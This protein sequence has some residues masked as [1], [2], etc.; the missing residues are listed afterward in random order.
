[1]RLR[2]FLCAM[3]VA[4]VAAFIGAPAEAARRPGKVGLVSF[5]G[6]SLYTSKGAELARLNIAWPAVRGAT[7]YQVFVARSKAGVQRTSRPTTSTKRTTATLRALERNRTYWVQVR[8]VRGSMTGDRSSRVARVTPTASRGLNPAAYPV[9]AVMSYNVCSNACGGWRGRQPLVVQRIQRLRPDVVSLQEASK[10]NTEVPG[11]AAATTGTNDRILYRTSRFEPVTT[12]LPEGQDST[13]CD[14]VWDRTIKQRV[15]VEPCVLPVEGRADTSDLVSGGKEATWAKLRD[16]TSGQEVIF[17]ALHLLNGD[18]D[19][20]A[21]KRAAQLRTIFT[22]LDAQTAWWGFDVD[23]VPVV[24]A[25]DFNTNRSREN[26]NTTARELTRRGYSDTY[27]QARVLSRQHYNTGNPD[28]KTKPV[29]GVTWGD[30]VDKVWTRADRGTVL[31]WANVGQMSRGRYTTPL[32]SD[33][34]PIMVKIQVS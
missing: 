28:W 15:V 6:S 34:H 29:I 24:F 30:H 11:Y 5:V 9:Y 22:D 1:M 10:W 31:S 14:H 25:G 17:V 8:A 27:E 20:A 26:N 33:H 12:D 18:G 3:A 32:P 16:R 2:L 4:L 23:D 21:G 19:W 7:R 13:K